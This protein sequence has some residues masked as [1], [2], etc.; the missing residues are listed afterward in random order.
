LGCLVDEKN[1]I[2]AAS[3]HLGHYI[4]SDPDKKG[5]FLASAAGLQKQGPLRLLQS[6][7]AAATLLEWLQNPLGTLRFFAAS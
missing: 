6:F 3:R 4:V 5:L 1:Q 2:F 7:D